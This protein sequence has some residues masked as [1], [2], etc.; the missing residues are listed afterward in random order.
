MARIIAMEQRG[1]PEAVSKRELVVVE[2]RRGHLYI[3]E[4]DA[5]TACSTAACMALLFF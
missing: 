4:Y 5:S 1:I 3:Y 2:R